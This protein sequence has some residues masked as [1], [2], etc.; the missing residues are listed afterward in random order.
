MQF[1]GKNQIQLVSFKKLIFGQVMA[2]IR[3]AY[4]FWP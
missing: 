2:Q 3:G 4:V 1:T